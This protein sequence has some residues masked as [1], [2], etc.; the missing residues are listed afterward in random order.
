MT[1]YFCP[2]RCAGFGVTYPHSEFEEFWSVGPKVAL[3]GLLH[4]DWTRPSSFTLPKF[5]LSCEIEPLATDFPCVSASRTQGARM[6]AVR[7]IRLYDFAQPNIILFRIDVQPVMTS[8]P[9]TKH[10]YD[11]VNNACTI[12]RLHMLA[13]YV[14]VRVDILPDDPHGIW[15][16]MRKAHE[17]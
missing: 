13:L 10:T 6:G 9:K 16:C 7:R 11:Q 12:S 2:T 14:F 1:P 4:E 3:L 8:S 15:S 5:W 17:T